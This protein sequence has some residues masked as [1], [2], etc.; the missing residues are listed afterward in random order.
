MVTIKVRDLLTGDFRYLDFTEKL[1]DNCL[2]N[3]HQ[4]WT[5]KGLCVKPYYNRNSVLQFVEVVARS[6]QSQYEVCDKITCIFFADK[7]YPRERPAGHSCELLSDD[8]KEAV[9]YALER[10]NSQEG[11]YYKMKDAL[12]FNVF[13]SC[14]EL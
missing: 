3:Y 14:V 8:I 13:E 2:Y 12:F 10:I 9:E 5:Y 11:T 7:A 1:W 6:A 4:R